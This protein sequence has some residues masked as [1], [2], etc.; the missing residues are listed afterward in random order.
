[1][2]TQRGNAT[3]REEPPFVPG[4]NKERI[5]VDGM[6]LRREIGRPRSVAMAV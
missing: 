2:Q 4:K 5:R 3:G 1:M 6:S